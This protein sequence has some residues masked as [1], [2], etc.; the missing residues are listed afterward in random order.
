MNECRKPEIGQPIA[1]IPVTQH[2]VHFHIAMHDAGPVR[3]LQG[4]CKIRQAGQALVAWQP[5]GKTVERLSV[6]RFH[7]D[8]REIAVLLKTVHLH[9]HRM[10]KRFRARTL[11]FDTRGLLGARARKDL[12]RVFAS[13]AIIARE[14]DFA[15]A[16]SAERPDQDVAIE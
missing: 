4:R 8:E 14:P 6:D 2:V 12:Q 10:L 7:Y 15:G 11:G 9:D 3:S 13:V 5:A 1:A 16:A